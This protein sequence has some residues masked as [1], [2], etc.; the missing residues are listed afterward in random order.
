M[1]IVCF[2]LFFA[3]MVVCLITGWNLS[4]AL[5]LGL[6]LFFGASLIRG[7]SFQD[8]CRMAWRDG[9]RSLIVIPI[10][11]LIG[12]LSGLWRSSGT[13]SF[14]L[15]Y[16]LQGISPPLFLLVAF[17]LSTLLSYIL[18]SSFGVVGTVGVVFITLARTGGVDLGL[19]A[20]AILSGAYFGDRCS[21]MS[22]SAS[23]VA[24][25]TET[26][27]YI[28]VRNMLHT[29]ILP[30]ALTTVLYAVFS[31]FNPISQVDPAVLSALSQH[32]SLS[33]LVLIP[34]ILMLGLQAL[35]VPVKWAMSISA[36]AAFILSVTLQDLPISQAVH[37]AIFGYAPA[38]PDL[39]G[40]LSGGGLLSLAKSG[41]MIFIASLYSG[42]LDGTRALAPIQSQV[43]RMAR[44]IGLFPTTVITSTAAAM[45]FCSQ[46][47]AI[48]MAAELLQGTYD[49]MGAR[50]EELALDIANSCV[51]V[52]ALIPWNAA[53]SVPLSTLNVGLEAVPWSFLLYLIPLCYL[54]TRSHTRVKLAEAPL[55]EKG[56]DAV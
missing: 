25:C 41:L 55:G 50:K 42:I 24:A 37:T 2:T 7:F 1:L 56:T 20:G 9:K 16:G 39:A 5:L 44:R 46:S 6:V 31:F 35:H 10:F 48:V 51:V 23:L 43:G 38:D 34:A 47:I 18:G 11:L 27:L 17:C 53:L 49:E 36:A 28:N 21:L 19:T 4:W 12:T 45:V 14:F 15:Y 54:F 22:S 33:P 40:I 30:T 52:S 8:L 3:A 13:I 26:Q 32:F 29:V